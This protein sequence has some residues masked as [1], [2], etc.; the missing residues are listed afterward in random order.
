MKLVG[1]KKEEEGGKA[2]VAEEETIIMR[3]WK[4]FVRH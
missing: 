3:R 4:S 2:R 1:R